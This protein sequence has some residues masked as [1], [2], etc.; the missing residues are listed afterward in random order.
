VFNKTIIVCEGSE[1]TDGL[2]VGLM[3]EVLVNKSKRIPGYILVLD[4]IHRKK[5]PAT[6][7]KLAATTIKVSITMLELVIHTLRQIAIVCQNYSCELS[8]L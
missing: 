7:C 8:K 6:L 1:F 3:L 5:L 4:T 2:A